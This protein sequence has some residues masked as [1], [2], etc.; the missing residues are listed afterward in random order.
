[1]RGGLRAAIHG[2]LS[3]APAPAGRR[4]GYHGTPFIFAPEPGA[5]HGRFRTERIGE[6]FGRQAYG[7]GLYDAEDFTLANVHRQRLLGPIGER[8]LRTSDNPEEIASGALFI[9]RNKREAERELMRLTNSEPKRRAALVEAK[10]L[11]AAAKPITGRVMEVDAPEGGYLDWDAP[12]AGQEVADR[13]APMGPEMDKPGWML[14]DKLVTMTGSQRAAAEELKRAG[15]TGI[16]YRSNSPEGESRNHVVFRGED[17]TIRAIRAALLALL[18]GAGA[19]AAE[20][21]MT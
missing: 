3:G 13:L 17:Y 1:M 10:R 7:H 6:G 9:Y 15:L 4:I 20:D 12:I 5:P 8:W 16:R 21:R 2:L 11:L 19:Y 14:H 18:G